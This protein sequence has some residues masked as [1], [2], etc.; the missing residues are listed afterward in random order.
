M[1]ETIR[2]ITITGL[3]VQFDTTIG[4]HDSQKAKDLSRKLITA[5]NE[6]LQEA[7]L[8]ES[9][10]IMGGD[11]INGSQVEIGDPIDGDDEDEDLSDINGDP[12]SADLKFYRAEVLTDKNGKDWSNHQVWLDKKTCEDLFPGKRIDEYSGSEIDMPE[13]VDAQCGGS[14]THD[15]IAQSF[16]VKVLKPG[17][18]PK[19]KT[20]CGHCGLSWDDD[21][22]TTWTPVPSGRCPF[23]YEHR[24]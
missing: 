4:K 20:T 3:T 21:I 22:G 1:S 6:A 24:H 8:D 13:F 17:E 19:G 5:I 15:P 18:N 2:T 14:D 9:P 12:Y 10:Q 11:D 7:D 23:E 16:P